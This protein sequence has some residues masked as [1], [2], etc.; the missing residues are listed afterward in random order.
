MTKRR[1]YIRRYESLPTKQGYT[2]V[3]IEVVCLEDDDI[4]L[5]LGN[6]LS[7]FLHSCG[8][9]DAIPSRDR[10]YWK[11]RIRTTTLA[12]I[13][14]DQGRVFPYK[15]KAVCKIVFTGTHYEQQATMQALL[16]VPDLN[17][18]QQCPSCKQEL[19]PLSATPFPQ[20]KCGC[21]T[22]LNVTPLGL[23]ITT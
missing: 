9:E 22:L 14:Q 3:G 16:R 6:Q 11:A 17:R 2:S 7:G 15:K 21:G 1:A 5:H 18:P 10:S 13:L 4:S 19:P 8:F 23:E 12:S 20:F